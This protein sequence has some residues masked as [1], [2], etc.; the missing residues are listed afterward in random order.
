[1]GACRMGDLAPQSLQFH[2][3]FQVM[4]TFVF[5]VTIWKPATCPTHTLHKLNMRVVL[6]NQYLFRCTYSTAQQKGKQVPHPIRG[7][8]AALVLIV[9]GRVLTPLQVNCG[10]AIG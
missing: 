8:T 2:L 3:Q 6:L 4:A 5:P 9:C 1:M 10:S 7:M